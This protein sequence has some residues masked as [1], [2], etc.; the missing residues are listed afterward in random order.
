MNQLLYKPDWPEARQRLT[1]WWNGQKLDRC[2]MCVWAPRD[3]AKDLKEPPRP[4]T[5]EER[6]TSFEYLDALNEFEHRSTFF[7]G[8]AVPVWHAGYPGH[9]AIPTFYGCPHQLDWRTGWHE[10]ILTGQKLDVSGLRLDRACR[11]WTWGD[12]L[13]N[14]EREV[15]AGKSIPAMG[16]IFGPGDTLVQLR[17]AERLLYDLMDDPAAVREAELKLM[18]DWI[19]VF[20]HQTGILT[21]DGG[22]CTNWFSLWAPGKCYPSQCDAS[23]GISPESFRECFIPAIRKQTDYLDY[24]VYHVD[25]VGAFHLVDELAKVDGIRALQ[26]LPG[27][28]K[29]SP[30]AYIDV[31]RRVQRL[32]KGLHISIPAEEVETALDLL[33]SRGLCICT[34]AKTQKQARELIELA[35]RKS[36]DRG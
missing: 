25:G 24:S 17:G 32:G 29:P 36:V 8:E 31:L 27:A 20:D 18:D 26:I 19:E 5:V 28:G 3:D 35:G 23:Y 10:P 2:L 13:L 12:K 6:W 21:R 14:H 9:V 22:P 4:A 30:L 33:S 1:A 7:G 15:S 11:W 34:S 16:A